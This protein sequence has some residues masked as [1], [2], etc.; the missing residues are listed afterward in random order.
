MVFTDLNATDKVQMSAVRGGG[1]TDAFKDIFG[2]NLV[3]VLF[4][5]TM[6]VSLCTPCSIKTWSDGFGVEE[7][8]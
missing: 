1:N 6:T 8:E 7:R 2:R 4:I 5:Y 3:K